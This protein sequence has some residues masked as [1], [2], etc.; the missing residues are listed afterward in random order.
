MIAGGAPRPAERLVLGFAVAV[1]GVLAG[2]RLWQANTRV[3]D[4]A[5]VRR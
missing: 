3:G 1:L 5:V 2:R 4:P